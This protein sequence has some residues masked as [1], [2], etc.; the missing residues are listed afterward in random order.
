LSQLSKVNYS[1]RVPRSIKDEL[2]H[3]KALFGKI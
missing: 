3:F 1:R 2:N